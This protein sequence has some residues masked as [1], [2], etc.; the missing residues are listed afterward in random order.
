MSSEYENKVCKAI[1]EMP[2]GET[3]MI[4]E[5]VAPENREKFLD[6]V[7]YLAQ[8]NYGIHDGYFLELN[9]HSSDRNTHTKLRKRSR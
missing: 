7:I 2:L 9:G 6:I 8:G 3:F 1:M 5:K 4:N